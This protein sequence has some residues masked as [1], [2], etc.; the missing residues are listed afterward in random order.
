MDQQPTNEHAR[1]GAT[2]INRW[3]RMC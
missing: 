3:F 2:T 1:S